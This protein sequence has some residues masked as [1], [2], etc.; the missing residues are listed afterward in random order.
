MPSSTQ[1][2]C[3]VLALGARFFLRPRC[4]QL[5]ATRNNCEKDVPCHPFD[6]SHDDDHNYR[7]DARVHGDWRMEIAGDRRLEL[8]L[9][10][11]SN[12]FGSSF[13]YARQRG[14][15]LNNQKIIKTNLHSTVRSRLSMEQT[16]PGGQ[17]RP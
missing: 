1:I 12:P 9:F 15:L 7:T 13:I 3:S 11:D 17:K 4:L 5:R 2:S 16:W 14:P 10:S 6:D 8:C